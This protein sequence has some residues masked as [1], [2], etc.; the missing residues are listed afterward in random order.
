MTQDTAGS[1]RRLPLDV[2]QRYLTDLLSHCQTLQAESEGLHDENKILQSQ[3]R[4]VNSRSGT[5]SRTKS[6]LRSSADPTQLPEAELPGFVPEPAVCNEPALNS[7][8]G[9]LI[10]PPTESTETKPPSPSLHYSQSLIAESGH[11]PIISLN[12]LTDIAAADTESLAAA[13]LGMLT[14]HNEEQPDGEMQPLSDFFE[15]WGELVNDEPDDRG[16]EER[17]LLGRIVKSGVF[18]VGC[19]LAIAANT[20]FIGISADLQV[21]QSYK[22]LQG[23]EEESSLYITEMVFIIWFSLELLLRMAAERKQF[24][25][26]EDWRWNVFDLL[27]VLNSWVELGFPVSS[28][29]SFLRIFRVFR[30]VR[31]VKVVRT[32]TSL[33]CLRT[34]VF[35]LMNSFVC[36]LWAFVMIFLVMFVFGVIIDMAVSG[37]FELVDIND[38]EQMFTA[39]TL[40]TYF[41]S[42]SETIISLFCSI[43]GGNDWYMYAELLRELTY[44][45]MYFVIYCFYISFCLIGVMNVVTGIFV[46]S[47]VCT[48]TEDEVV[49]CYTDDVK[50]TSEEVRRI[51]NDADVDKNGRMTFEEMTNH[52]QT[53][54]VKAYFSGLDIDPSEA[55]IIFTL[56]DND[57]SGDVSINEFVDGTL[58]LKGHARNIDVLSIM[59]D[60]VRFSLKFNTL[61][62]YV[63]DQMREIKS[64]M[65]PHAEQTDK[66]FQE[67]EGGLLRKAKL[68]KLKRQ[69][70]ASRSQL[71]DEDGK[72]TVRSD[73]LNRIGYASETSAPR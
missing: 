62:C 69:T 53:P 38:A 14:L 24:F 42:L 33:K 56:M 70:E 10:C 36:L 45:D 58:R 41:G 51:F 29:L 30:L 59:F 18:R 25:V 34:M 46:D 13:R 7:A 72:K 6:P 50:R 43:T 20:I 64:H 37:Y 26:G 57:G 23:V 1:P 68:G 48:R 52:M 32:V 17:T 44:G 61:C 27:L 65:L 3:L 60:S 16:P 9:R 2:C 55:T 5:P 47:A 15:V 40:H 11:K 8:T 28:N 19:I 12:A 67:A 66:M 31:V 35:A 22:R 21:K 4:A 63:E 73:L 54:W 49:E 39:L 71:P